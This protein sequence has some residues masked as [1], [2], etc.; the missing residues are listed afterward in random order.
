MDFFLDCVKFFFSFIVL[1]TCP[2]L[3]RVFTKFCLIVLLFFHLQNIY[4]FWHNLPHVDVVCLLP[5]VIGNLTNTSVA[6][7]RKG[8]WTWPC[9]VHVVDCRDFDLCYVCDRLEVIILW[10]F[11]HIRQGTQGLSVDIY[12]VWCHL[13]RADWPCKPLMLI[14]IYEAL[15]YT[16]LLL[17]LN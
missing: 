10:K 7:H 14:Y 12:L 8:C 11:C 17:A 13:A 4:P 5:P 3:L 6:E 16:S 1:Q 15:R 2:I 9:I